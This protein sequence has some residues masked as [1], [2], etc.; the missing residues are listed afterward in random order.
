MTH[1]SLLIVDL[2]YGVT[3]CSICLPSRRNRF[4]DY[5]NF[6]RLHVGN[7]REGLMAWLA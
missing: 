1:H 3:P 7:V 2:P 6:N 4:S 5:S